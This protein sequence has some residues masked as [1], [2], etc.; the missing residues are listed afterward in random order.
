MIDKA[1][2]TTTASV[3][4]GT[5][6]NNGWYTSD[7][8]VAL[9]ASDNLSGVQ[10]TFY[11]I[12][13]GSTQ[14]YT[15]TPFA[16]SGDLVHA[17][18]CWS[19]D[20]AG[21]TE[22]ANTF[23]VKIDKTPPTVSIGP[24][25]ATTA[26]GG[27]ISYTVTYFDANFLSSSLSTTNVHLLTTG[28]AAGTLSF[29]D[30]TGASR[31]VTISG[32]SGNG[33]LAISIDAGSARDLAGNLALAAG[34]SA[35]VTGFGQVVLLDP[36][37]KGALTASGDGDMLVNGAS[38][39]V[40]D[41]TNPAA[42]DVDGDASITAQQFTFAGAQA[43]SHGLVGQVKT[44][45]PAD[46]DPLAGLTPPSPASTPQPAVHIADH[47]VVTLLPGTY[48]GG[49][50]ISGDA[51]VT[52][53]PGVYYLDEGGLRVYGEATVVGN[54]VL[55]YLVAAPGKEQDGGCKGDDG[56]DDG[57][58][59]DEDESP[60]IQISGQAAVY[61]T[62]MTSGPYAGIALWQN[63]QSRA[64]VNVS[65]EANVNLIGLVDVAGA[66][67]RIS[68]DSSVFGQ[69][70][71]G[72]SI[73]VARDLSITGDGLVDL[74]NGGSSNRFALPPRP[75]RHDQT[76]SLSF[77][78]GNGQALI[79]SFPTA[80]PGIT[81]AGAWL[82]AN[83]P[84]LFQGLSTSSNADVAAAVA[85]A[86]DV[87][88]QALALGLNIYATTFSLGGQTLVQNGLAFQYDLRVTLAGAGPATYD[89]GARAAAFGLSPGQS[90]TLTLLQILQAL[91]R[92][93][94]WTSALFFNGNLALNAEALRV[95]EAINGH[96]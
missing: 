88:G 92:N 8:T 96:C 78:Q 24:P 58:D 59:D 91:D 56:S 77:W 26:S 43:S 71:A 16:V 50:D 64:P 89:V 25:S 33:S 15:S 49:I 57:H 82:A 6:G 12:D 75:A 62:A 40:V 18:T 65:G 53:A 31:T 38:T 94:S 86:G 55:I 13:G 66:E 47:K 95:L 22:N 1:P 28:S 30:S 4:S 23:V 87:Y 19:V 48:E 81:T 90:T 63:S 17:V 5:L 7:V 36:T 76:A 44:D 45:Q 35:A 11:Q 80:G 61:L 20:K 70:V 14:T 52:L 68:G 9:S 27:S 29:D 41:S 73:L 3:A 74:D 84:N 51:A 69:A 83:F 60:G 10:S 37:G 34:S 93:Y 85:A 39:V 72:K 46:G 42:A 67:V 2:P 32:I 54:G 79:K 21:N